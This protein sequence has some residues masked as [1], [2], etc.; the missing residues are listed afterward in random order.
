MV[1][2]ICLTHGKTVQFVVYC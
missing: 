1:I 2:I